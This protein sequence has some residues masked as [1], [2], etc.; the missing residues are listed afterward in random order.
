MDELPFRFYDYSV[1]EVID[2][3]NF[4]EEPD[5]DPDTGIAN[6]VSQVPAPYTVK[7][8][9]AKLDRKPSRVLH[10]LKR[11]KRVG[12]AVETQRGWWFSKDKAPPNY[13]L[14]Y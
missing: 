5:P 3:P 12:R 10:S 2:T 4:W 9:A 13:F 8:I 7:D 11:L 1:F 14:N 6:S